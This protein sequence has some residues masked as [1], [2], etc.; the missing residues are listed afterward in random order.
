MKAAHAFFLKYGATENGLVKMN[1]I[2]H[3]RTNVVPNT[4]GFIQGPQPE[5]EVLWERNSSKTLMFT[6][7]DC[8]ERQKKFVTCVIMVILLV[9]SI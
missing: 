2:N 8:G 1:V 9:F 7:P 5:L 6:L 4:G 3:L